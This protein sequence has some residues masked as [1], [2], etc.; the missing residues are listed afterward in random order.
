MTM[1]AITLLRDDHKTVEKLFKRFEKA[2]AGAY[3]EKATVADRIRE[4]LS[5]H[6]AI[7]EQLFYP[8][9]LSTVHDVEDLT[10]ERPEDQHTVK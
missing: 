2:G 3:K 1:D 10:P 8:V 6:A 4:E 7:E 9:I 5:R